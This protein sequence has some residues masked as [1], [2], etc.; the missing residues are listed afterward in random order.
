MVVLPAWV[1]DTSV[2]F[3]YIVSKMP[4]LFLVSAVAGVA[5]APAPETMLLSAIVCSG[6]CNSARREFAS[7]TAGFA[8]APVNAFAARS[9]FDPAIAG[10]ALALSAPTVVAA[11]GC[12]AAGFPLPPL[13]GPT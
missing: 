7:G 8:P 6:D 12:S 5:D 3:E 4:P 9:V 11:P 13:L 2:A 10:V 1:V